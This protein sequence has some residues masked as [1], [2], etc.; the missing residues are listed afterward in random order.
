MSD[1]PEVVIKRNT[2]IEVAATIGSLLSLYTKLKTA[3]CFIRINRE[4][5]VL[6]WRN[7]CRLF[8]D[9]IYLFLKCFPLWGIKP[10]I[11]VFNAFPGTNH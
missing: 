10:V 4:G 2:Q 8:Q 7:F 9:G 1:R 6:I 5:F 11:P 3:K